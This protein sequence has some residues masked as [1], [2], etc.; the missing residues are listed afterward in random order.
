MSSL[1]RTAAKRKYFCPSTLSCFYPCP[2]SFKTNCEDPMFGN[3]GSVIYPLTGHF[4]ISLGISL[5]LKGPKKGA[6]LHVPQERGPY[7][8]RRPFQSLT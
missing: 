7:G 5:F 3:S 4:Y 6:F 1:S 2:S 8:K